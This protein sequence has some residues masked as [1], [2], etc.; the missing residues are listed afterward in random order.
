MGYN[1][2]PNRNNKNKRS[3]TFRVYEKLRDNWPYGN[4]TKAAWL[5]AFEENAKRTN[6]P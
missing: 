4:K 3:A 6:H 2:P 1:T 5:Q